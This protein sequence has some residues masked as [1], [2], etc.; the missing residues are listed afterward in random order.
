MSDTNLKIN[1]K[2]RQ[3]A[4]D[5]MLIKQR[6]FTLGLYVTGHAIERATKIVGWEMAGDLNQA[7][8]ASKQE[9]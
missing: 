2:T 6:A 7:I 1:P 5:L 4:A 3:Y 9:D 8:K